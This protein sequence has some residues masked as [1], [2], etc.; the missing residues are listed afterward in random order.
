MQ[1][2][3]LDVYNRLEAYANEISMIN[4]G[5][6]VVINLS[7]DEMEQGKRKYCV[8]HI[9]ANWMKRFRTGEM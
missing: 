9:E 2:S 7:K 3:F 5:N 4:P 1:G 6:D 8:R